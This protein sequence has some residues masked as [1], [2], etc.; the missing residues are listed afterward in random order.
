MAICKER[1]CTR[2]VRSRVDRTQ[3]S[4]RVE[5]VPGPA[6]VLYKDKY[7]K[8]KA[9]THVFP[10]IECFSG[11]CEDCFKMKERKDLERKRYNEY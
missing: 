10:R 8:K 3:T 5:R 11:L 7:G 4:S 9:Y 6:S 1:S 2:M